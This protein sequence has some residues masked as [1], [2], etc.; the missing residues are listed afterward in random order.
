MKRLLLL[1]LVGA[2]LAGCSDDTEISATCLANLQ[3]GAEAFKQ[4]AELLCRPRIGERVGSD[5]KWSRQRELELL[6]SFAWKDQAKGIIAYYGHKAEM[7]TS[8]GDY[9]T[10]NYE[11]DVDPK[12]KSAPVVD[13]QILAK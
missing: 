11:C 8:S 3:C 5:L 13:V 7:Q 9:V 2:A 6:S 10:L 12:N 1:G 4:Q